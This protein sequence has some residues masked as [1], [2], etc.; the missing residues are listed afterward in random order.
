MDLIYLPPYSPKYNPIEHSME[1]NKIK[2]FSKIHYK[3]ER[4]KINL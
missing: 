3:H 4:T 1:N 2:N